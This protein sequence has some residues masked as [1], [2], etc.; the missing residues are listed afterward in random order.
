[1]VECLECG[2]LSHPECY[3]VNFAQPSAPHP[4]SASF[5]C[6]QCSP[7]LHEHNNNGVIIEQTCIQLAQVRRAL[8]KIH[9]LRRWPQKG[10]STAIG[11]SQAVSVELEKRLLREGWIKHQGTRLAL[12]RDQNTLTAVARTYFTAKHLDTGALRKVDTFDGDDISVSDSEHSY[13][14]TLH[15]MPSSSRPLQQPEGIHKPSAQ[16]DH[17]KSASLRPEV[18]SSSSSDVCDDRDLVRPEP[19]S[20]QARLLARFTESLMALQ[21][22]QRHAIGDAFL[23]GDLAAL[24]GANQ[25]LLSAGRSDCN[26][27]YPGSIASSRTSSNGCSTPRGQAQNHHISTPANSRFPPSSPDTSPGPYLG[28]TSAQQW[29]ESDFFEEELAAVRRELPPHMTRIKRKRSFTAND[30][31]AIV[32]EASETAASDSDSDGGDGCDEMDYD[33]GHLDGEEA[34][35]EGSQ[36]M[37]EVRRVHFA[38]SGQQ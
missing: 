28:D 13:D 19:D 17:R 11:C 23:R 7:Q 12:K 5:K 32:S 6:W 14:A 22:A 3:G 15:G 24:P 30:V 1:M 2:R 25:T 37:R 38:D 9:A 34:R 4:D 18:I 16:G 31:S 36:N 21:P 20:E 33:I 8:S 27:G 29:K 26:D 10:L 35:I